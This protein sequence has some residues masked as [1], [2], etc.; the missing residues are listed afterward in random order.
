[1][2]PDG[3]LLVIVRER[4]AAGGEVVNELVSLPAD[5]SAEPRIIASGP[6]STP[7]RGSARTGNVW[8]G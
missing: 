3:R 6:D 1:M 7:P 2:T 4:H 8:P 5:G